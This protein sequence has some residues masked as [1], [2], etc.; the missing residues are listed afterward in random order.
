MNAGEKPKKI[1]VGLD[2]SER[3]IGALRRAVVLADALGADLEL[4]AVWQYPSIGSGSYPADTELF[5]SWA[6]DS[7]VEAKAKVWGAT[8]PASLQAYVRNGSPA[9]VL[10]EESRDADML[11]VGSRGH[12]GFAGL[13]LGSVSMAV[14]E[15]AKCPVLVVHDVPV[16]AKTAS[17]PAVATAQG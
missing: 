8:P 7:L 11:V 14:A 9:R 15:H 3:S 1:V 2:G 16:S 5:E 6:R 12:G 4:V 10:I 17:Q 13:M